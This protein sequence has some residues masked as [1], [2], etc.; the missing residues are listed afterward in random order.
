MDS[1]NTQVDFL[2]DLSPLSQALVQTAINPPSAYAHLPS[3]S[4]I[5]IYSAVRFKKCETR[6][7]AGLGDAYL[8]REPWNKSE[9]PVGF[10]ICV[11]L[12]GII[13]TPFL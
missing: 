3:S 13:V 1:S 5:I 10:G 6:F 2:D 9:E 7:L 12:F 4:F 11:L 8:S